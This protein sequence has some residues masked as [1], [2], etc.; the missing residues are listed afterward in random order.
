MGYMHPP[1]SS[2]HAQTTKKSNILCCSWAEAKWV[3][4]MPHWYD[5]QHCQ[6]TFTAYNG[7]MADGGDRR[8]LALCGTSRMYFSK[9]I[10]KEQQES[11]PLQNVHWKLDNF[12]VFGSPVFVVT[13]K[14]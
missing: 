2:N 7:E 12:H 6:N 1:A 14:L 9:C 11:I 5:D 10:S 4:R 3:G 13:R 8:I